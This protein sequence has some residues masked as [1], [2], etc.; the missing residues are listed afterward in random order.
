MPAG[1]WIVPDWWI[2][3]PI[4]GARLDG[5]STAAL[6]RLRR[7]GGRVVDV[8][9]AGGR[10]LGG[11]N[12]TG[13]IEGVVVDSAGSPIAGAR[14]G[15]VGWRQEAFTD[16][17]GAF[18]LLGMREGTYE[19]RFVDPRLAGF[20]L[21]PPLEVR[22]VIPGEVS[23][24]QLHMPPVADLLRAACGAGVAGMGSIVGR[25]L[26]A[27]GR[28]IEGATVRATLSRFELRGGGVV[29]T[30]SGL[31]TTTGADGTY[32]LCGVVRREPLEVVSIVDGI[33]DVADV[34][35][36][37]GDEAGALLEIRRR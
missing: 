7:A 13:G 34:I 35:T 37:S 33:E 9:E 29:R 6:T 2:E 8:H 3:M 11:R 16:A 24:I 26:D 18:A 4:L 21:R 1:T 27:D 28:A 10:R 15:A 19:V 32:R 23:F 20:G 36:I 31:E 17:Q 5:S 22:E 12:P 30:A 25:V 14:V